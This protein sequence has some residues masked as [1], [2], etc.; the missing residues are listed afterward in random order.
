MIEKIKGFLLRVQLWFKPYSKRTCRK[1]CCNCEYFEKY[2][3]DEF[4]GG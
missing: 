2:C 3:R 1:C 4:F